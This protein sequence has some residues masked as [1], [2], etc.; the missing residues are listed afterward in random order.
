[1][2]SG[3]E[4]PNRV[5]AVTGGARGIGLATARALH[6]AGMRVAIG[7]LDG[8]L[9]R[10]AAAALGDGAVGLDLDVTRRDS[11]TAFLDEAET[12]L[13]PV[14]VLVNNAG[15]MILGRFA[16]EEDEE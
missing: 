6:R 5:A 8:D 1:M 4:L 3:M 12:A 9:A 13:G 10:S 11:F 16:D 7:D 2:S 15:I 14:D